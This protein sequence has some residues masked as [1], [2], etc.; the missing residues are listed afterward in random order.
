MSF[1]FYPQDSSHNLDQEGQTPQN[2]SQQSV[3]N[4][5]AESTA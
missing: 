2:Q 5:T 3:E 1:P 4:T